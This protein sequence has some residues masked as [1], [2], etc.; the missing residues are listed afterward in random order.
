MSIL[1]IIA[2]DPDDLIAKVN[3]ALADKY[4]IYTSPFVSFE[5]L[6]VQRMT[7][8]VGG[9]E[10]QLINADNLDDLRLAEENLIALG[11]DYMFNTIMWYGRYLQWMGRM[12]DPGL[13]VRDAIE[14]SLPQAADIFFE[15]AHR[16]DELKLVEGVRAALRLEPTA[17]KLGYVVKLPYLLSS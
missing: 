16:T 12:T 17:D 4:D 13:S 1:R 2:T 8:T 10:Y 6:L 9:Y 11:Y 3:Q 5:G 7:P 14:L 15:N